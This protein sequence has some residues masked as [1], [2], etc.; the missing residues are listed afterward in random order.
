[1]KTIFLRR[2][3]RGTHSSPFAIEDNGFQ[4]QTKPYSSVNCSRGGIN[5]YKILIRSWVTQRYSGGRFPDEPQTRSFSLPLFFTVLDRVNAR[6]F[7]DRAVGDWV[8][9]HILTLR[10]SSDRCY[11]SE[12]KAKEVAQDCRLGRLG[13]SISE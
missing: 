5:F 1:M 13:S 8:G 12:W 9:E 3:C 2:R 10:P 6:L 4:W 7:A 11:L